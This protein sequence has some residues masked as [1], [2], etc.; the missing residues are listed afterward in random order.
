MKRPT[1][2]RISDMAILPVASS[3]TRAS[4][5]RTEITR[6]NDVTAINPIIPE[7]CPRHYPDTDW[8]NC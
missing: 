2:A 5:P 6:P 4:E 3:P 1:V 7:W 8:T